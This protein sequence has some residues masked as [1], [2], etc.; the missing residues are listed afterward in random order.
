M[1][2][3][4]ILMNRNTLF[5]LETDLLEQAYLERIKA[6]FFEESSK[7]AVGQVSL[8]NITFV[9]SQKKNV[10]NLKEQ[11][12]YIFVCNNIE[13][14]Q[15]A[16]IFNG[17]FDDYI[18]MSKITPRGFRRMITTIFYR[19]INE[20]ENRNI[21]EH[22]Y[23]TSKLS[24]LG[25][26]AGGIAHELNNPLTAL[27]G[28]I[29]RLNK[30][31]YGV[32]E[33]ELLSKMDS[34]VDRMNRVVLGIRNFTR[35]DQTDNAEFARPIVIFNYISGFM[36][37]ILTSKGIELEVN[38]ELGTEFACW[39]DRTKFEG[40]F[41]NLISNSADAIEE[42]GK[43]TFNFKK[44]E[45][46]ESFIIKIS[47]TGT[48]IPDSIKEKIFDPFFTTKELGKGTGLGMGII[49]D[50][51]YAHK[52]EIELDSNIDKGTIFTI[53][54]PTERRPNHMISSE[55][56]THS[57]KG[58]IALID[59][60]EYIGDCITAGLGEDFDIKYF[61]SSEDFCREDFFKYSLIITDLTMPVVD[62][63]D[64]ARIVRRRT[65]TIPIWLFTGN[66]KL[67]QSKNKLDIPFDEIIQKPVINFDKLKEKIN[68]LFENK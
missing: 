38:D 13:E 57:E 43:I 54:F 17:G 16:E 30:G 19:K 10:E 1:M 29:Y 46:N 32:K 52:G 25:L 53:T 31:T 63:F 26:L 27:K 50:A 67:Y 3:I 36:E 20:N 40:M 56:I 2:N 9:F 7:I 35:N 48:G 42:N 39:L 4:I 66:R 24:A 51:I 8:I 6:L 15:E 23:K 64:L 55:P 68:R 47:D 59:D 61:K 14:C 65:Q 49:M 41:Q 60:D 37:P 33:H 18:E 45:N 12:A 28:Y 5:S 11:F 34:I 22:L 62:G 21:Q 58:K 44:D